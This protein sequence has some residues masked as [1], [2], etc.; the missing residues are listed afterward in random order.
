M[1]SPQDIDT[2]SFIFIVMSSVGFLLG[3]ITILSFMSDAFYNF[4]CWFYAIS[5]I[6]QFLCIYASYEES[7]KQPPRPLK[8][9]PYFHNAISFFTFAIT[10]SVS[11]FYIIDTMILHLS[12]FNQFIPKCDFKKNLEK[13]LKS[14]STMDFSS[15]IEL[16]VLPEL[17]LWL[18]I[19]HNLAIIITMVV[20]VFNILM[21]GYVCFEPLSKKCQSIYKFLR[22][23]YRNSDG[24][25][26]SILKITLSI[27]DSLSNIS[28]QLYKLTAKTLFSS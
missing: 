19:R 12:T 16:L 24:V 20:Y 8:F 2:M 17:L 1:N 25:I 28:N 11:I 27:A 5:L 10:W 6:N 15:T 26:K 4:N 14:K 18:L 7:Q 3:I 9:N 21:F 22:N 23:Q 13:F